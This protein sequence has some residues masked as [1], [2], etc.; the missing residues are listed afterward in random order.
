MIVL[1]SKPDVVILLQML[2]KLAPQEVFENL[3]TRTLFIISEIGV[4]V[5][6]C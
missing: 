5:K 1:T 4:H 2:Q 6:T 3:E